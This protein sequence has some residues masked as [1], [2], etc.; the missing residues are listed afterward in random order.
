MS[1]NKYVDTQI[2]PTNADKIEVYST[3]LPKKEYIELA[4]IESQKEDAI[5]LK[6]EAAELGANA[7]IMAKANSINANT[8]AHSQS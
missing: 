6:E 1:V 2:C 4:E 5:T 7:I 8:I 3:Q